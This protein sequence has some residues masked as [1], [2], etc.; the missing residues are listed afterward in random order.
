[1][2]HKATSV[3]FSLLIVIFVCTVGLSVVPFSLVLYSKARLSV[4]RLCKDSANERNTK[5]IHLFLFPNAAYL[6]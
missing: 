6:L 3:A 5:Q 2:K 4:E 1:M